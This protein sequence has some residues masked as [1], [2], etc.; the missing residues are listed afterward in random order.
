MKRMKTE[1]LNLLT[2]ECKKDREV[3]V[4]AR[5]IVSLSLLLFFLSALVVFAGC[6]GKSPAGPSSDSCITEMTGGNPVGSWMNRK[7]PNWVME[8]RSDG[9]FVSPK[10]FWGSGRY[11][12][13]GNKLTEY[14]NPPAPPPSQA[15]AYF[16]FE[17]KGGV[18]TSCYKNKR[19]YW[20]KI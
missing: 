3:K 1:E 8:Y 2:E 15:G 6:G 17:V 12:V 7:N 10:D 5:G 20:D 18:L 11:E 13:S 4:K 16:Y 9:T 19:Y 14:W